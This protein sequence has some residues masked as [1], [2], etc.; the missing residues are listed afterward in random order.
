MRRVPEPPPPPKGPLP[1][2]RYDDN[3]IPQLNAIAP[4]CLGAVSMAGVLLLVTVVA[5]L[6][7]AV[8]G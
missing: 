8:L 7:R 2:R 1:Q 3:A 4:V 6:V 5:Q